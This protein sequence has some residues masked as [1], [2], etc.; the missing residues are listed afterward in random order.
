MILV[1]DYDVILSTGS[2]V[3]FTGDESG[4]QWE[5]YFFEL[6]NALEWRTVMSRGREECMSMLASTTSGRVKELEKQGLSDRIGMIAFEKSTRTL[7]QERRCG[8]T[9]RC[10]PVPMGFH[11]QSG[12]QMAEISK[13]DEA[14]EYD[15]IGR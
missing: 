11:R 9:H 14:C 4:M 10:V 1:G 7:R 15:F 12:R 2:G 5:D 13:T 3:H 8:E 6:Q